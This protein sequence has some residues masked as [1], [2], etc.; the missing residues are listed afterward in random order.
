MFIAL[1]DFSKSSVSESMGNVPLRQAW[2]VISNAGKSIGA[3]VLAVLVDADGDA[4]FAAVA[5]IAWENCSKSTSCNARFTR[6]FARLLAGK[7][8]FICNLLLAKFALITS[9]CSRT[10]RPSPND[11]L[12]KRKS[13]NSTSKSTASASCCAS[14]V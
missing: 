6:P 1:R 2:H 11:C 5:G 7:Y 13:S 14:V 9:S 4:L 8:A 10:K 12:P 3:N